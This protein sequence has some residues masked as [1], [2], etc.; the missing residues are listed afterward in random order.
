MVELFHEII[1]DKSDNTPIYAIHTIPLD[2]RYFAR[3]LAEYRPDHPI[4]LV[5]LPSH[6]K[7]S[8]V[9]PEGLE[10]NRMAETIEQLRRELNHSKIILLGHGVGGFV[11]QH[12]TNL[13]EDQLDGICLVNSA[14]NVKYRTTLAWNIRDRYSK[15]TKQALEPYYGETD[16]QSIRARFTQS[17][18][19]Y[20]DPTDHEEAKR[21][22]NEAERI[23]TDAYVH[24]STEIIPNHY[25][26]ENLRD[27][28][29]KVLIIASKKD[30][31]PVE[32]SK[33][34]RNDIIHA[35]YKELNTGHFPMLEKPSEFWQMIED[36]FK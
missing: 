35:E 31:W 36:Y 6:G 32:A 17:L 30:V 12:Y 26:R 1:N 3:S 21:I 5:D 10:F 34:M 20:F 23:A 4:V 27:V 25:F 29:T 22:M 15:V 14:G 11:V 2:S 7:S 19:V 13:H 28:S 8:D 16:D 18:A 33:L 24:L 9:N